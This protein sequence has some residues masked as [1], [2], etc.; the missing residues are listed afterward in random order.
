[1]TEMKTQD[2]LSLEDYLNVRYPLRIIATPDG[3]DYVVDFPDLPGCMTQV[4]SLDD[5]GHIADEIRTLWIE[6]AFEDG[7]AIPLP[8]YPAEYSGRFLLRLPKSLHR[9]LSELA[10][11][12]GVSLNQ[13]I[14]A[15]L[16]RRVGT[17]GAELSVP[18]VFA[19]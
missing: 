4:E 15:L 14:V 7:D 11:Q 9:E 17:V 12:D 18:R 3:G 10:E 16:S 8:S 2:R 6:T 13:F 1:M 19:Q 5:V